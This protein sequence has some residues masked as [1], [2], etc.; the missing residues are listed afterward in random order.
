MNFYLL[1]HKGFAVECVRQDKAQF[2]IS[3]VDVYTEF[4]R[5][6]G[7]LEW[8]YNAGGWNA[9][10]KRVRKP[11]GRKPTDWTLIWKTLK[12]NV[13]FFLSSGAVFILHLM[14]GYVSV[15]FFLLGYFLITFTYFARVTCKNNC[16][17]HS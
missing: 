16:A 7:V 8:I 6:K 9:F 12:R 3:L 1:C 14:I 11:E 5:R 15:Y 13:P 10:V 2:V 17:N 4:A